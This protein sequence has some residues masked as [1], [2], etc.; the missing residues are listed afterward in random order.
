MSPNIGFSL[1]FYCDEKHI[2]YKFPFFPII[3]HIRYYSVLVSGVQQW[4][5]NQALHRVGPVIFQV[6]LSPWLVHGYYSIF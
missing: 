4:L 1:F 6:P 3:V 2:T 5:D